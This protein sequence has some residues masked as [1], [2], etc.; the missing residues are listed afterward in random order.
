MRWESDD[1]PLPDRVITAAEMILDRAL[2]A[3]YKALVKA[4]P[5]G[6]PAADVDEGWLACVGLLMSLDPRHGENVFEAIANLAVDEQLPDEVIPIIADG[7][8]NMICLDYRAGVAP[9]VVYWQHDLDGEDAFVAISGS[10]DAFL[11]ILEREAASGG[12]A[13]GPR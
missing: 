2:P 1:P 12:K 9:A 6:R 4:H 3:S 8:G 5:G 13:Q 10:F 11:A 7:G